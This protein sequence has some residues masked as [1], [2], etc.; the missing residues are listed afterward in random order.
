MTETPRTSKSRVP[1]TPTKACTKCGK[2][3]KVDEFYINRDW[4]E[5][6]G[7]DVWC[8]ECVGRCTSKEDIKEYCW[9]NHRQYVERAWQA[10]ERRA[11]KFAATNST[12][13]CANE[14][15]R[16]YILERLTAQNYP[17]VMVS[18]YQ[19]ID[20]DKDDKTLSYTE[21]KEKGQTIEEPEDTNTRT[22][23][24]EFNGWFSPRD[25]DYLESYY[26]RLQEDFTFEDESIRDYARKVCKASL[27]ADKAQDA[28]M[29]GKIDYDVVK[30]SLA[31]FDMLS[32]SANFAACKRKPGDSSG[33]TSFSELTLKL[34]TSGHPMTRKIE[35]EKDDVDRTIEEFRHIVEAV[36][37][38]D[39]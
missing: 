27:Q 15:R 2:V 30:D 37:L 3:R 25:L 23:S 29:L 17:A 32:K 33:M 38:D 39:V 5:Q 28:Y 11:E 21:A 4:K 1:K 35:W 7:R 16:K 20:T 14:E 36:G 26:K 8:K 6:L 34:E 19:Y 13:Q 9:E 18:Y 24:T 12:Y 31:Q 22:Y 10:A